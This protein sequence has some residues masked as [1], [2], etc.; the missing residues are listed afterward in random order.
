MILSN[1]SQ[2]KLSSIGSYK[3]PWLQSVTLTFIQNDYYPTSTMDVDQ[4]TG[5][6]YSFFRNFDSLYR[7]ST[8]FF[9]ILCRTSS[10]FFE[11][12]TFSVVHSAPVTGSTMDEGKFVVLGNT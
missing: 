3:K 4:V 5:A 8:P 6:L 11:M 2:K 10:P 12:S 1:K 7:T 9:D